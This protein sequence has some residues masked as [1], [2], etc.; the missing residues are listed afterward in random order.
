M[1]DSNLKNYR[2]RIERLEDGNRE[3]KGGRAARGETKVQGIAVKCIDI[4]RR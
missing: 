2:A 3:E 4:D 1:A